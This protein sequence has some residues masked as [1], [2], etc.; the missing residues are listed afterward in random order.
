ML[1]LAAGKTDYCYIRLETGRLK[2]QY[3]LVKYS[4]VQSGEAKR[5]LVK[6][7]LVHYSPV[8]REQTRGGELNSQTFSKTLKIFFKK[9]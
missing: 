3:S 2:V 7:S 4:T 5:S 8:R 9:M 6:Y 1:F